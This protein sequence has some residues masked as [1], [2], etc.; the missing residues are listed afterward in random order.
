LAF[1]LLGRAQAQQAE[2]ITV[3]APAAERSL[4]T[5]TILGAD[6]IARSGTATIGALLDQ[7][8][9]FGS[10]GVNDAQ[11][12]GGFGEHFIDMRNL[13]FDRTLVLVDGKRFV[14][15]GIRTDEAVDL[16]DI[17]TAFIDHV[18]I[19]RDGTQPQDAADAV[20]GVVNIVLRDQVEGLHM[21]AYGGAADAGDAGTAMVSLLAGHDFAGGHVVAG[22][23]AYHR[24]PVR[25]SDRDWSA[26]PIASANAGT[27]ML[28]GS[29]ATPGGHAVGDGIDALALGG[30]RTRPYDASADAYNP[31]ADRYLQGGLD[32][33]T[34]YFDAD[35]PLTDSID[36]DV[37]LL[38]TDRRATTLDPPQSLGLSGTI[39]HPDGFNLPAGSPSDPFAAPVSLER[40]TSEA[41][42]QSTATSGPV[43]RVL[44][45][46]EG[47][48]GRWNWS[49]SFDHGQS[50]SRYSTTNDIDLTRAL[51]AAGSDCA[52]A[53]GC[54]PANFFGPGS[55][56]SQAVRYIAYTGQ[57]QSAYAETVG[58]ATIGGPILTLPGGPARLTLG[59]EIRSEHG[60]TTVDPVTARGDQAAD[61]AAPT[62][63]GYS[64]AEAYADLV[65]PL[66][67]DVPA[68]RRLTLS[69]TGRAT[70]TSRYGDFGTFR[71][72]VDY[73]PIPGVKLHASTGMS[74]RPPAISESFGGVA[75][76]LQPV[77]DPCDASNGLRGNP[78]V[79]A[80]CRRQGLGAGFAQAS[81]L[82]DVQSGG[83]PNLHP[84][85]SENET[86][87]LTVDPPGTPWL[88]VSV[89]WYH[90]RIRDAIDSLADTDPN[91]IPDTCYASANLSS[92]LCS[93]ITRLAGGGNAG[94][95]SVI[96]APDQ[97][98]GT[99]KTD[100]LEF[101]LTVRLPPS[102][103]GRLTIDWQ[104]NWLLDYRIRTIG[105][106]GGF[107]QYAGTF[108]GLSDVGSYARVRSR[109]KADLTRGEWSVGWTGRYISGA[110]VLGDAEGD[111]Y[112][113]AP[114][115]LYQDV[116]VSRR[117]AKQHAT[118]M[119]GID[120]L[121]DTRPPTLIDGVTNT[122]TL[123]YDVVG[124]FIWARVSVAF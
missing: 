120:N 79:D 25:Q 8:P 64:T 83:N 6:E 51:Q 102:P 103:L 28:F 90:Y 10:Q 33:L 56:S 115:I 70:H 47:T 93:L 73:A 88:S 89:D 17:P 7:L 71:A 54:V 107:N 45:G 59:G 39:K 66:L 119:L 16:N 2:Q 75:A 22:V 117:F 77:A 78:V 31:A 49:V 74:R 38:Y 15:S 52:V 50:L 23:E 85:Q 55:L 5:T 34:G 82:I 4:A 101:G 60:A 53:A 99:I 57:A 30:G 116:E 12:D 69:L 98:V 113:S 37:E 29:P 121:C 84:E 80:N 86:L 118:A 106:G 87:G 11:N 92:P 27:S 40:V 72:A 109:A 20:A 13:N 65:L 124:R 110:K 58:Q 42:P 43:W 122:D 21:D 104:T 100:G 61:D 32:R 3:T 81:P 112:S 76:S 68:I 18:E 26:D 91:L 105:G 48:L 96:A 14:P 9:A 41:G 114:G 108:P 63:G 36:A 97:N 62:S 94:Q 111:P 1:I 123:T 24:D 35:A 44:A 46:L 95:I 67:R 19:L